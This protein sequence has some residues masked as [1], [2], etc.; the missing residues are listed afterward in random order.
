MSLLY[1]RIIILIDVMSVA[2]FSTVFHL[3]VAIIAIVSIFTNFV[4]DI[5][6]MEKIQ[7]EILLLHILGCIWFSSIPHY[8]EEHQSDDY[9]NDTHYCYRT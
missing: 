1:L 7:V 4:V 9:Q 6:S 5:V 8:E 3:K 2:F